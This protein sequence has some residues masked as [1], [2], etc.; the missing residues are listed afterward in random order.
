M[1][2]GRRVTLTINDLRLE[3]SGTSCIYDYIDVRPVF[4]F[5]TITSMLVSM[6]L[7]YVVLMSL[8]CIVLTVG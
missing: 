6:L 1:S 7:I 2:P 3:D 5:M 4:C 8:F